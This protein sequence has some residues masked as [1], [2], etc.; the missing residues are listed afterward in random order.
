MNLLIEIVSYFFKIYRFR[1]KKKFKSLMKGEITFGKITQ[2]L[3]NKYNIGILAVMIKKKYLI[4]INL[5]KL[6]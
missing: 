1:H 4:I 6:P 2:N 3:L 5:M